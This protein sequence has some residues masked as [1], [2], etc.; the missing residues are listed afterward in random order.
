MLVLEDNP[1]GLLRYEGEPLP[2]LFS[3]DGGALRPLPGDLL[4]DPLAGHPPRLGGG[5]GAGA[6]QDQARQA[7]RRP[8]HARRSPSNWSR[9]TSPRAAGGPTSRTCAASTASAVTP[10]WTRWPSSSR[11]RRSGPSPPAACSS[12]P[13]CPTSSTPATCSPRRCARRTSPS[14]P[15]RPP[16]STAAAAARC[17]STS[18][19]R[20]S[21]RSSRASAGSGRSCHEQIALYGTFTGAEQ[22]AADP[23]AD[24]PVHGRMRHPRAGRCEPKPTSWPTSCTCRGGR[25]PGAARRVVNAR[26]VA[27]LKGGPSLERQ[28]SLRSGARVEDALERAGGR[29]R[30]DRRR[31]PRWSS[32]CANRMPTSP[33]SRCTAAAARTA[34]SRRSSRSSACPTPARASSPACG[35]WTRC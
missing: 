32:G 31:T 1:Y 33:S 28:V 8:V 23:Q 15:V 27:V 22:T 25:A 18:P 26:R 4:Q 13:R 16:T 17:G 29:G 7:G 20:T 35:A 14:C 6:G 9:P 24:R 11:A 21:T 3:L 5:A 19:A 34:P 30:P 12:G 10:C 2:P